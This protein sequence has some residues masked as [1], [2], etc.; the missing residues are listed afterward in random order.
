MGSITKTARFTGEA[1][2]KGGISIMN[3]TSEEL[4]K[5]GLIHAVES[6]ERPLW[7]G[8]PNMK[9]A[10][11][12]ASPT[13][14][15]F[16]IILVAY[17]RVKVGLDYSS[18]RNARAAIVFDC[19][20][21]FT[22]ILDLFII[23]LLKPFF[24]L[25]TDKNINILVKDGLYANLLYYT[26]K[27]RNIGLRYPLNNLRYFEIRKSFLNNKIGNIYLDSVSSDGT[28]S[29]YNSESNK[30][31]TFRVQRFPIQ[32]STRIN[33]VNVLYCV[34]DVSAVSELLRGA[35]QNTRIIG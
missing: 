2:V 32:I 33:V 3:P 34:T 4:E 35:I 11:L 9:Y 24:Y 22:L 12:L 8:T 29:K 14:V 26:R 18:D 6:D 21:A 25:I 5:Y 31:V 1:I 17:W 23:L 13:T 28:V 15:L 16:L 27:S 7:L 30:D 20:F 10:F 19:I